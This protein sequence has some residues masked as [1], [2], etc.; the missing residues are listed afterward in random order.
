MERIGNDLGGPDQPGLYVLLKEQL[1]GA[2]Q[3]RAQA[4]RQ[5]H[6]ADMPQELRPSTGGG[7]MPSSVGSSH[8][9]NGDSAHSDSRMIFL[10]QVVANLDVFLVLM[11]RVVDRV[12]ALWFKKKCPTWR[13]TIA[14]SQPISAE[15]TGLVK[16]VKYAVRKL[17]ALTRCSD[18]LMRLW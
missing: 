18:W 1:H 2:E 14:P 5:P 9:T 6:L 3:Q 4:Q 15:A 17:S 8:S 11:R 12:V 16:M 13:L 7:N 10:L